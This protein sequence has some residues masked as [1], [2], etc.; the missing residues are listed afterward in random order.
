MINI[1]V[2]LKISL[3]KTTHWELI[4]HCHSLIIDIL[5]LNVHTCIFHGQWFTVMAVGR[6]QGTAVYKVAEYAR[7]FGVPVI[8]DRGISS[9]GH[10]IKALALGASTGKNLFIQGLQVFK[11]L[12]CSYKT[13]ITWRVFSSYPGNVYIYG[14]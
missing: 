7:R 5:N 2:L 6:P 4:P 10:V 11:G 14:V 9:V 1:V 13:F 8:A 3:F 12:N